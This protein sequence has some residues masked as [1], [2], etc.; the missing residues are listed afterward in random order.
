MVHV[1][2][3]CLFTVMS[4]GWVFRDGVGVKVSLVKFLVTRRSTTPQKTYWKATFEETKHV[5]QAGL[6]AVANGNIY[7]LYDYILYIHITTING[8]SNQVVAGVIKRS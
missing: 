5:M 4:R 7:R 6:L 2:L 3:V 1:P 8:F